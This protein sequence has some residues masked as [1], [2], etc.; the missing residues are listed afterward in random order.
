MNSLRLVLDGS[1]SL[2][3][4]EFSIVKLFEEIENETDRTIVLDPHTYEEC[5][6]IDILCPKETRVRKFMENSALL[7]HANYVELEGIIS[8]AVQYPLPDQIPLFWSV[9]RECCLI[10]DLTKKDDAKIGPRYYPEEVASYGPITVTR[11]EEKADLY[12]YEVK[13]PK[14]E[15][16]FC[17]R[18][19]FHQWQ[20]AQPITIK[21]LDDLVEQIVAYHIDPKK[22]L[23]VHCRAGV[24]RTGSLIVARVLYSLIAEKKITKESLVPTLKRLVLQGRKQRGELFVQTAA[25]LKVLYDWALSKL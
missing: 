13:E 25:Q 20:D 1:S 7:L 17:R 12:T 15:P 14:Q 3:G 4:D 2:L 10:V 19:H 22:P 6:F 8:I 18:V 9:A 23:L 24:G 16:F 21:E 11:K 5:R